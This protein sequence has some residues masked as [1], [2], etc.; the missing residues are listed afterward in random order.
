MVCVARMM[1]AT[2]RELCMAVGATELAG[3]H[4]APFLGEAQ[5]VHEAQPTFAFLGYA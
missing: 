2:E 5:L 1:P 3:A 4:G